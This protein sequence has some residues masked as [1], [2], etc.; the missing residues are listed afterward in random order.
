S[1]AGNPVAFSNISLAAT[2]QSNQSHNS[3]TTTWDDPRDLPPGW[4]QVDDPEY[5]TFFVEGSSKFLKVAPGHM[6]CLDIS[7]QIDA[8]PFPGFYRDVSLPGCGGQAA[9]G[10]RMRAFVLLWRCLARGPLK[11]GHIAR[12]VV[13]AN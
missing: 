3:G 1:L 5:G 4:E 7:S 10:C 6:G 12:A 13:N 11:T 8:N 9:S 2:M